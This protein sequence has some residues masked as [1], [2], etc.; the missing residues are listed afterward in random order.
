[1]RVGTSKALVKLSDRDNRH[2]V[3]IERLTVKIIAA[4]SQFGMP[5]VSQKNTPDFVVFSPSYTKHNVCSR[6]PALR[7]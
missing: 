1:M 5:N 2:D 6:L 4:S 3:K 7:R